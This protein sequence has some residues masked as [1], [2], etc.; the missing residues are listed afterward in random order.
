MSDVQNLVDRLKRA[1]GCLQAVSHTS[2]MH[3]GCGDSPSKGVIPYVQAFDSLLA[4][5]MEEYL[6]MSK[7]I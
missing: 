1:V 4:I 3:C 6:K 7:E 5:P 2:D